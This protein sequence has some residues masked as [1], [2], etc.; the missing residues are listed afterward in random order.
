MTFP[1]FRLKSSMGRS[2]SHRRS[3]GSRSAAHA[4]AILIISLCASLAWAGEGQYTQRADANRDAAYSSEFYLTPSNV[5]Q[6]QFGNLFSYN[7]DGFVAAQPLYAPS[8]NISGVGV[9]NV[10]YV[11]T[12]HDSVYAFNADTP[13]TGAPLW[14]VNFLNPANGVTT[15]PVSALG[16]F[17]VTNFTEE[18][19]LGTP[20]IDPATNTM[21][22]VAKTQEV[23][24]GVTS[25]VFR[26]HALDITSGAEKF[27]GP[28]VITASVTSGKTQVT[29]NYQYDMQR[30]ALLESNGSVFIGFGSN[31]CDR[32]AHGWLLAY[33]ASTLQQQAVFNSS[34]AKTWGSSIWMSGVGPAA[35]SEG[36]IYIV[37][38]NGTFDLNTGGSDYGDTIMKFTFN[39]SAF[40]V[41]DY[42]TPFNQAMMS[43]GDLDL[44]AGGAVILPDQ[45]SGPPHLLVTAGKTGTIYLVNRDNMGKYNSTTDQIVQELPAAVGGIWGAPIYWNNAIYFAGRQDYIKAFPFINGVISTTPVQ[46][47][48]GYSLQGIPS[49]SA[50]G[51]ANGVLW[52][53]REVSS[54]SSVM[55]LS[56]FNA[57]TLQTYLTEVF[58]TQQNSSRDALGTAPHFVTPAIANGKLYVG[59]NTQLKVYGLFPEL[60]PST[61]NNQTGTV[62]APITLTAQ[63]TNPYSGAALANVAVTFSDGGRGGSF[64]P[65]TVNTNSTGNATTAYTL[66]ETSGSISITAA[67]SGYSTATFSETANAGAPAVIAT[68]SGSSQSGV[69][70]TTLPAPLVVTVKDLY[71]NLVGGASVSY[72]DGGL[73]GSKFTPNPAVTGTNGQASSVY[74]LPTV[75]K[76]GYAVTASSGSA[77]SATFHETSQAGAPASETTTGG[78][79]QTGTRGT[80]LPKALVVSV[81]D[82]YGNGVT[83]T[84]VTFTDNGA[85]GSFSTTAPL[86][87]SSGNASVT[88]TLPPNPGT[89]TITA[90]VNSLNVSFT[91]TSK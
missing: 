34:A 65:T 31:G 82:Q 19:I 51:T 23:T 86:T 33:G 63:A 3:F 85:G 81:K 80:T 60:N 55:E 27:G 20:V 15:E 9:V 41:A 78:N 38:A 71:G 74:T 39:G 35:D 11:A 7:V 46:T 30:P 42:F 75:A 8:V 91:E 1:A 5:N 89:I 17:A 25:Y 50:N 26:L 29:L 57:S 90:S 62:N 47:Q 88:Y 40:T 48:Y 2:P 67:S 68:L 84:A 44:G 10:V 37:T 64:N 18:G 59:T 45:P 54:S 56:A 13:G 36:N 14:Q 73:T 43:S 22:L 53:V 28:T 58:N 69:V 87:N 6:N 52:L 79:K 66:P 21:Y 77:T 70:A 4:V 16:C 49:L 76:S 61:G 83:N 32:N 12:M 72:S 24:G